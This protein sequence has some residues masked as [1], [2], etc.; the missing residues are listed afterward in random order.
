[1][2]PLILK[3]G[4]IAAVNVEHYRNQ[5]SPRPGLQCDPGF[6]AELHQPGGLPRRFHLRTRVALTQIL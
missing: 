4:M 1:M 2:S 3:P 6:F 5:R